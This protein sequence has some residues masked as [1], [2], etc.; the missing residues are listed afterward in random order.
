MMFFAG[1]FYN[2]DYSIATVS[3]EKEINEKIMAKHSAEM[4]SI[5]SSMLIQIPEKRLEVLASN[6]YIKGGIGAV[7]GWAIRNMCDFI[8]RMIKKLK[9]WGRDE[10]C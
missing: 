8:W 9:C 7:I 5:G 1:I 3:N 2:M 4:T 6:E 10:I